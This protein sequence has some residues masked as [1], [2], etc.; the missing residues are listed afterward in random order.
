MNFFFW[1]VVKNK[2]C[3]RNPHTLN[4]LKYYISDAFTEIDGDRNL[5]CTQSVLDRYEVC[6]NVEGGHFEQLTD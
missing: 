5:C 2:V 6:C 3:D 4:E 1:G